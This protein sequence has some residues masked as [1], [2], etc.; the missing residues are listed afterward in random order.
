MSDDTRLADTLGHAPAGMVSNPQMG[1]MYQPQTGA[2]NRAPTAEDVTVG[3]R[4]IAPAGWPVA[5]D[6]WP[7]AQHVLVSGGAQ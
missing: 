5:P 3:A 1:A 7:V 4:F 2:I 6:G